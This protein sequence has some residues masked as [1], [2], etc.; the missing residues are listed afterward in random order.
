MTESVC[1]IRN[2]SETM[3][4]R[5]SQD[6]IDS[7]YHDLDQVYILPL[8]ETSDIIGLGYLSLMENHI[9]RTGM[10]L[11]IQP[12]AHIL[13]L[14]I[15]RQRLTFQYIIDKQR[16]K[17][18]RILIRAIVIRAVCNDCRQTV[19]IVIRPYKMVRTCLAGTIWTM[20]VILC[21]L[22][23]EIIAIG[24]VAFRRCNCLGRRFDTLRMVHCQ[25]SI[26]LVCRDMVKAFTFITI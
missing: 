21:C 10:V 16:Y 25:R 6:S 5:I 23:K 12:V 20:R 11:D 19:C 8:V 4:F 7:L 22:I 1:N 26:N 14:A 13:A 9:N 24:L 18:L 3:S 17:L 15:Y 2:K